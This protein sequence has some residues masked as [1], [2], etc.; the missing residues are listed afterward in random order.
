MEKGTARSWLTS[1]RLEAVVGGPS[2]AGFAFC[3]TKNEYT[4][5]H[6]LPEASARGQEPRTPFLISVLIIRFS[7]G[8]NFPVTNG[9]LSPH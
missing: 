1:D 8:V 2:S 7:L 6:F 4:S 5:V 3:L 9:A